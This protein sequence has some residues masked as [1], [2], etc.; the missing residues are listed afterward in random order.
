[1]HG[2]ISWGV[3]HENEGQQVV[4]E[5]R[6]ERLLDPEQLHKFQV[7]V[8]NPHPRDRAFTQHIYVPKGISRHNYNKALFP[9]LLASLLQTNA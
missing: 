6:P 8:E 4:A 9:D 3:C 1:M 7:Q 2:E 5:C